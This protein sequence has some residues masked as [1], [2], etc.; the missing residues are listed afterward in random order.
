[1]K[2][3]CEIDA[4]SQGALTIPL[5]MLHSSGIGIFLSRCKQRVSIVRFEV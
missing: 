2:L 1:M 3:E 5:R 4:R